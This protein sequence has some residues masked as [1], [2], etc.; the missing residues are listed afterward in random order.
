M[1]IY[2]RKIMNQIGEY[3]LSLM[4]SSPLPG[5]LL[6]V[7]ILLAGCAAVPIPQARTTIASQATYLYF[8]QQGDDPK[9]NVK[10]S[11]FLT[12]DG[13][14]GLVRYTAAAF[15]NGTRYSLTSSGNGTFTSSGS[16][17]TI[18]AGG[19]DGRGEFIPGKSITINGM[20]FSF[21]MKLPN[22]TKKQ[23]GQ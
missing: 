2:K 5:L 22:S 3:R 15:N 16:E 21:A 14:N 11:L 20:T 4:T 8:H 1:S 10:H 17:I 12:G 13:T 6:A 9:N 18:K 19:L 23:G 7:T